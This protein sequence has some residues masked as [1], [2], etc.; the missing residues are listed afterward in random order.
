MLPT[1]VTKSGIPPRRQER[2]EEFFFFELGALCAFARD[3]V[4]C[5]AVFHP[6]FQMSL[7]SL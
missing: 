4:F 3:T 5:R 2:K 6:K 7:A 1:V